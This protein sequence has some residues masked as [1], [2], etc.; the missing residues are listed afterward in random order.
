MP[1]LSWLSRL[2]GSLFRCAHE[3]QLGPIRSDGADYLIC[4]D[5]GARKLYTLID[6]PKQ[7]PNLIARIETATGIQ[8]M[9]AA[10]RR[11]T[12]SSSEKL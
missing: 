1:R 7:H 10:Q 2:L 11:P 5:C 4:R 12:S 9:A 8:R 3:K 6:F